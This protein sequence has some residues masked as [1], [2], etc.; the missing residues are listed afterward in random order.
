MDGTSAKYIYPY[1]TKYIP[2]ISLLKRPW[3]Y[4]CIGFEPAGFEMA[5]RFMPNFV[6][7]KT[8]LKIIFV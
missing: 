1:V 6:F 7:H 2:Y 4:Y 3:I 5:H 8:F